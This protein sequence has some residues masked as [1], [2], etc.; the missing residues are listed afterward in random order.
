MP[1]AALADP[2]GLLRPPAVPV[3]DRRPARPARAPR[4]SGA[5]L[6]RRSFSSGACASRRCPRRLSPTR[7]R[8]LW[9]GA[10]N[11]WLDRDLGVAGRAVR[12]GRDGDAVAVPS[13]SPAC[14]SSRSTSTA[15]SRARAA[16]R[17]P[18]APEAR[19]GGDGVGDDSARCRRAGGG[20]RPG[21]WELW[22]ST[23]A[24]GRVGAEARDSPAGS[25]TCVVLAPGPR[26]S[27]PSRG[28]PRR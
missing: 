15:T 11:S 1:A 19:C 3:E 23:S 27:A 26:L 22:S 24:R 18:A 12:A 21:G 28:R 7:C 2:G 17:P 4:R 13:R 5:S 10:A 8:G 25:T 14:R 20:R 9:R 6:R 16:A